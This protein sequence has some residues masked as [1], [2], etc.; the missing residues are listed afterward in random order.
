MLLIGSGNGDA[1]ADERC[2]EDGDGY[3]R[4]NSGGGDG[5]RDSAEL[6]GELEPSR[7]RSYMATGQGSRDCAR[8]LRTE[9]RV[10]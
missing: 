5:E 2:D 3:E 1:L 9:G 4:R 7:R 8:R 6:S 10:V